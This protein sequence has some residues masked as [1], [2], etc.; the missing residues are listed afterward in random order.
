MLERGEGASPR[1]PLGR[2]PRSFFGK[3]KSD[4]AAN[5]VT[6][7]RRKGH[8]GREIYRSVEHV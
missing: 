1:H 5:W 2:L 8:V 6:L 4:V 7:P 3:M